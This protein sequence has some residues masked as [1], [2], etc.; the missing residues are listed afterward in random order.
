M[1]L[2]IKDLIVPTDRPN[3][4]PRGSSQ[5]ALNGV[6]AASMAAFEGLL[7]QYAAE[8]PR[9][10]PADRQDRPAQVA[11]NSANDRERSVPS[12]EKPVQETAWSETEDAGSIKSAKAE[13]AGEDSGEKEIAFSAAQTM[14]NESASQ[15][16]LDTEAP[17]VSFMPQVA[18]V[19]TPVEG[20]DNLLGALVDG[21][22]LPV[23]A[24][25]EG[26]AAPEM[27]IGQ[28]SVSAAA[29]T[30]V[31]N[32]KSAT[33]AQARPAVFADFASQSEQFSSFSGTDAV[34]ES[35]DPLATLLRNAT[36]HAKATVQAA[37]G[38]GLQNSAAVPAA[39]SK[40][41]KGL[42]TDNIRVFD[43]SEDGNAFT[44]PV[45]GPGALFAQEIGETG[46]IPARPG[47]SGQ[48][49]ASVNGAQTNGL[50]AAAQH[51]GASATNLDT[52]T[53][54]IALAAQPGAEQ[55]PLASRFAVNN[56]MQVIS[57]PGGIQIAANNAM[58]PTASTPPAARASAAAPVP[59]DDVAVHIAR[60]A[61]T[62][63]DHITIKLKPAAL[64]QIDVKM[65]LTHDGRIAAVIT[66]DRSDT[67]DML[68][69]DAKSLERAL[70]D[71]GLKT[72]SGSLQ[73]NL[74]GEGHAHGDNDRSSQQHLRASDTAD[75]AMSDK[76]KA[77]LLATYSNSRAAIGGVD[78]RV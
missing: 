37:P 33:G 61:A 63:S 50:N 44:R 53:A 21:N 2:S 12:R 71:A 5:A 76:A 55:A 34:G 6:S 67:L 20:G 1:E 26:A 72:D 31:S 78:I 77:A 46:N 62:G 19:D 32:G 58:N 16:A 14:P 64:G 69:R 66:A 7:R 42:G 49:P 73:F 68:A 13:H 70:A 48:T 47:M 40:E 24:N 45:T 54:P 10:Q 15:V 38:D 23:T 52:Q 17:T 65:E 28:T 30:E 25:N 11:R 8:N 39:L 22:E 9:Q 56:G 29:T 60:A 36:N 35:D 27:M 51:Q 75:A 3:G 43:A 59:V 74:R 41:V 57:G 18:A 4:A